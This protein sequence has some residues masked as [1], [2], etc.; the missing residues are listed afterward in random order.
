VARDGRLYPADN[1]QQISR[2]IDAFLEA[3]FPT[4]ESKGYSLEFFR[5]NWIAKAVS[6]SLAFG[7]WYILVPGAKTIRVNYKIPVSVEHLPADLQIHEL[8]PAEIS[9]T[10]NGPRRAF[11]LLDAGKIKVTVDGTMTELGR[12]TFNISEQNIRYPK[13]LTLEE[14]SPSSIRVSVRKVPRPADSNKS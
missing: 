11:Y 12:R 14:L 7:F 13:D 4:R 10:F 6:L 2:G 8:Q 3:K 1:L 5:Q 9:A